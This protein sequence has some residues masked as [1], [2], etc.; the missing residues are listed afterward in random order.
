MLFV[1]V[2]VIYWLFMGR[3]SCEIFRGFEV[4]AAAGVLL[5]VHFAYI[6]ALLFG[7]GRSQTRLGRD[8]KQ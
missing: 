7:L 6:A 4:C 2:A 5:A 3:F 8:A 1:V